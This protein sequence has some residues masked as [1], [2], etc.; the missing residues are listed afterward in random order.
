MSQF[1]WKSL[2][3]EVDDRSSRLLNNSSDSR[4][5]IQQIAVRS[6]TATFPREGVSEVSPHPGMFHVS[7]GSSTRK[8]APLFYGQ[9]DR[10][11]S[12]ILDGRAPPTAPGTKL[13]GAPFGWV[14]VGPRTKGSV[15]QVGCRGVTG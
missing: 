12:G 6:V 9:T 10:P 2:H 14:S 8:S 15:S 1:P 4:T 3:F 13:L 11:G 7:R 5:A